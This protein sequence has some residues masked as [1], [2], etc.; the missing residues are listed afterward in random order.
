M[1]RLVSLLTALLFCLP[2]LLWSQNNGTINGT[3]AIEDASE[4]S[5]KLLVELYR[6]TEQGP[7]IVE[8]K[9]TVSSQLTF[10]FTNL[11]VGLYTTAV[12]AIEDDGYRQSFFGETAEW[13]NADTAVVEGNTTEIPI[14]LLSNSIPATEDCLSSNSTVTC[15]IGLNCSERLFPI[16]IR[17]RSR[18]GSSDIFEDFVYQLVNSTVQQELPFNCL[19]EGEYQVDIGVPGLRLDPL[20]FVMEP[21]E[22]ESAFE[23]DLIIT[24]SGFS[25]VVQKVLSSLTNDEKVT[26][27]PNPA[28]THLI[29]SK[30]PET[31]VRIFD[32]KGLERTV[33]RTNKSI[34]IKHLEAGVYF[35]QYDDQ[36]IRFIVR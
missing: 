21:G 35:L 4:S 6:I 10:S 27:Y 26:I 13:Q 3:I 15:D 30:T 34:N 19:P 14:T 36:L 33:N 25:V 24:E 29:L 20:S 7:W 12:S 18:S 32:V 22:S 17:R 28:D 11:G 23:V 2:H 31:P 9:D 8:Q 5:P 1:K 16:V